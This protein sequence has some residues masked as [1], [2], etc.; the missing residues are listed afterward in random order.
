MLR[1]SLALSALALGFV[2]PPAGAA[3]YSVPGTT[4]AVAPLAGEANQVILDLSGGDWRVTRDNAA[5]A[6]VVAGSFCTQLTAGAQVRCGISGTVNF[7]LGDGNDKVT[8]QTPGHG[9][10]LNGEAG[11]DTLVSL[12]TTVANLN[13]GADN[14][15]LE[16]DGPLAD[17]LNGGD[18]DDQLKAG[19]GADV[20]SGGAGTDT[21]LVMG[22]T[23]TVSLDDVANDGVSPAVANV[24]PDVENITGGIFGDTLTGSAAPNVLRGGGGGDKLDGKGGADSIFGEG[25]DD[26]IAARDGAADTIDC[27]DGN[28]TVYVDTQEDGVFDCETVVRPAGAP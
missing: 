19:D 16:A 21:F 15:Y 27:G 28:D 4:L 17:V 22:G 18:G 26:T 8:K 24:R 3:T 20:I 2:A 23:W 10:T 7:S 25:G 6:P 9:G 1:R 14:D 13:G 12:D 11:N 5:A